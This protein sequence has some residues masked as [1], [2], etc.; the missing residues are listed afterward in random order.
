MLDTSL[1]PRIL[2]ISEAP[3][4]N[5][6]RYGECLVSPG[7]DGADWVVGEWDGEGWYTTDALTRRLEPTHYM[8]GVLPP[9]S[10]FDT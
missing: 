10:M 4:K 6:Q 1:W 8:A 7:L 3:I 5:E 2:P 9:R